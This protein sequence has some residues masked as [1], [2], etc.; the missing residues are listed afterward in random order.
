MSFY[1]QAVPVHAQTFGRLS[2]Q[3]W[4]AMGY[5]GRGPW[6]SRG[7]GGIR[8]FLFKLLQIVSIDYWQFAIAISRQ[9]PQSR[10]DDRPR[11][12]LGRYVVIV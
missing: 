2:K 8:L 6:T 10:H 9:S 12:V 7:G 4:G 11:L 5:L 1:F 3:L